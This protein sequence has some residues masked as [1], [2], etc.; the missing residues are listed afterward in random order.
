MYIYKEKKWWDVAEKIAGI[1]GRI[2]E[3]AFLI[4]IAFYLVP[5]IKVLKDVQARQQ[6]VL[7]HLT[8]K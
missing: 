2:L 4:W 8:D 7:E 6:V 1:A 5:D 3:I